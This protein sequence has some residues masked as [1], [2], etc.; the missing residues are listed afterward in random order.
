MTCPDA[1][2]EPAVP[3]AWIDQVRHGQLL[4]TPQP[5]ECR[6][7]DDVPLMGQELDQAVNRITDLYARHVS[8]AVA[9]TGQLHHLWP[10]L[11]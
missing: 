4:N 9:V 11:R 2:L 7:V 3:R 6:R 1:V 5:L 10:K 8:P